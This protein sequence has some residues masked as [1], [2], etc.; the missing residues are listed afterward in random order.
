[1]KLTIALDRKRGAK[2]AAVAVAAVVTVQLVNSG[3]SNGGHSVVPL[4]TLKLRAG[5]SG[6]YMTIAPI[7]VGNI[8]VP[9]E[10]QSQL[11][12]GAIGIESFSS[13]LTNLPSSTGTPVAGKAAF[14]DFEFTKTYDSASNGLQRAAAPGILLPTVSIAVDTTTAAGPFTYQTI[15][16]K[17]VH[18]SKDVLSYSNSDGSTKETVT[19][20]PQQATWTYTP[21]TPG[22]LPGKV[23]SYC[24]NVALNKSC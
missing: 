18:V 20:Q 11:H 16:L 13:G 1:M 23:Q 14:Q 10:A 12:P 7:T 9:G 3:H 24:W 5:T 17:K 6:A 22:G 19:M 2:L 4:Q 8:T 21:L 15:V